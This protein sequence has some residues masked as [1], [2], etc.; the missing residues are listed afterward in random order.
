MLVIVVL[1]L[2]PPKIRCLKS[3]TCVLAETEASN[4][5]GIQIAAHNDVVGCCWPLAAM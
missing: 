1:I 4:S 3:E 2:V 5:V